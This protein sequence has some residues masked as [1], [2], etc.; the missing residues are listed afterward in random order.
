MWRNICRDLVTNC[1]GGRNVFGLLKV[2][3]FCVG[4]V[5]IAV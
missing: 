5:V 2:H 4:V 3:S 1:L